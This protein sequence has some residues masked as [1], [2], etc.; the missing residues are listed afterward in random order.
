MAKIFYS[1]E[2]RLIVAD[3]DACAIWQDG[4][5]DVGTVELAREVWIR[6]RP[7]SAQEAAMRYPDAD[8]KSIPI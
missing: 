8:L 5:W 7:I 1:H 3:E 4:R 6:E 2:A